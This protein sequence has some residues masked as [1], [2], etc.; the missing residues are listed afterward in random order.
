MIFAGAGARA[1]LLASIA[2]GASMA[3]AEPADF[4]SRETV[5]ATADL[6][7]VAADGERS[8]LDDSFGKARWS[9]ASD[10]DLRVRPEFGEATFAWMPRFDWQMSGTIVAIA[11]NGQQHDVD[12]SEAFLTFRA[13]NGGG[14]RTTARFGLFWPP[15]SLEHG[16][17]EWRVNDTITP[18]AIGSWIGEEVKVTGAEFTVALPS[19][20]GR[21]TLTAAAFGLNDTAG[22]LMAFRG[23]ALHDEKAVAFGKQPLPP[24]NKF[25][26]NVQPRYTRPVIGISDTVGYYGK[27]TW[28]PAAPFRIEAFYYDNR[29]DPQAVNLS[30]EWGWRTRFITLGGVARLGAV[31]LR[32]QG[33]TGSTYMGYRMPGPTGVARWVDTDY[34]SAYVMA[35]RETGWGSFS[36]R[37]EAFGTRN[38]G[39]QVIS[40]DDE[41]GW[42]ATLAARRQIGDHFSLLAE[43]QRIDSDK[44]A[45]ARAGVDPKQRQNVAQL[46]LRAHL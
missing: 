44:G 26:V 6:R 45:R 16:G 35:T 30:K 5:A 18:S 32:A 7:L 21:V 40:V 24:L 46:A 36:G 42:A 33:L 37:I 38:H 17:T 9:G 1:G 28:A 29:A 10:G 20:G 27:L 43:F 15:V 34:R 25:I 39:S 2:F 19:G 3:R 8:W 14:V 13:P 31:T 23:W 41:D 12:L 22:T 4:F 11:Q